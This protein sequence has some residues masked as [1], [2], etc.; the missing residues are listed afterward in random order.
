MPW[1][2]YR[3]ACSVGFRCHNIV[4]AFDVLK[5][6]L[7]SIAFLRP[8][9]S[10]FWMAGLFRLATETCKIVSPMIVREVILYIKGES[11]I[12]PATT[13]GG[14]GLAFFLF[15]VVLLQ[16]CALQHFIHGGE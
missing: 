6:P 5:P 4:S 10:D 3:M 2:C 9:N 11:T 7:P 1:H 16:A 13:L 15:L 12:V 8:N 14:L